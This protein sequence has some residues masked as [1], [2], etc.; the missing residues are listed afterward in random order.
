MKTCEDYQEMISV[1]HD[2]ELSDGDTS[3]LFFH[4]GECSG[5][6]MFMRSLIELRSAI[7]ETKDPIGRKQSVWKRTLSISYPVAAVISVMILVSSFFL[8]QK[9]S[10][11]PRIIEKTATEYVYMTAFP[12]VYAT[13]NSTTESK[14]N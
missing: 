7:G 4:L 2:N 13:V 10:E 6:R 9:L 3:K 14:S 12:P 11:Q 5:C 1:Y 8:F